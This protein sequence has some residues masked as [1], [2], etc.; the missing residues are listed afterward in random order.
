[1]PK[2]GI[3]TEIQ[4][5]NGPIAFSGSNRVEECSPRTYHVTFN[6]H[7]THPRYDNFSM[8]YFR[9]KMTFSNRFPNSVF[10]L[11]CRPT[12]LQGSLL[13]ARI[14]IFFWSY[15]FAFISPISPIKTFIL[16]KF[17]QN[18]CISMKMALSL[19]WIFRFFGIFTPKSCHFLIISI[20]WFSIC[21]FWLLIFPFV[22]GVELE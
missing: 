14:P 10:F 21:D 13:P 8:V 2:I 3:M 18:S 22:R 4:K 12:C 7:V 9:A 11:S 20:N 17:S 16:E 5:F 1:M 19:M 15:K 6:F